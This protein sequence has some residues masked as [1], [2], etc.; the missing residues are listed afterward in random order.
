M[1]FLLV[2][3]YPMLHVLHDPGYGNQ[4]IRV[5]RNVRLAKLGSIN[6]SRRAYDDPV[7]N[8]NRLVEKH[9]SSYV[10]VSP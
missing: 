7:G 5:E 1:A 2:V 8:F 3:I 6:S 10:Y 4:L 9:G